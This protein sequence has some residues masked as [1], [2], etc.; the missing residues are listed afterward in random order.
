M[1]LISSVRLST[2]FLSSLASSPAPAAV[3]R[4]VSLPSRSP[5]VSRSMAAN[6]VAFCL[7]GIELGLR[8]SS[9]YRVPVAFAGSDTSALTVTGRELVV[10]RLQIFELGTL[11]AALGVE[12]WPRSDAAPERPAR[13]LVAPGH[14]RRRKRPRGADEAGGRNLER[15]VEPETDRVMRRP[16][17]PRR[18][19][20][21]AVD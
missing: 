20:P 8:T 3:P 9:E 5:G 11:L 15:I 16:R 7:P 21:A 13:L 4:Q 10:Q 19:S 17:T 14:S 2:A 12:G 6:A 18:R 1:A